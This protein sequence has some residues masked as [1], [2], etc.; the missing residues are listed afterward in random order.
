MVDPRNRRFFRIRAAEAAFAALAICASLTGIGCKRQPPP[1]PPPP[2]VSVGHPIEREVLEWD[3]YTA[4]LE[5]TE[6]VEVRARV[7]GYLLSIHFKDGAMVKKGDLL[8]TI[9]PRPYEASLHRM[10]A[11]AS[12]AKARLDLAQRKSERA[13]NLIG[14]DAI[15][16]EEA[17][18]RSA[19]AR[20]AEASLAAADADIEAAKLELEFTRV[21]APIAGR[22]SRRY[23]TEGNLVNGGIGAQG[24]LLT[25]IVS[26]DP[27]YAYIEADERSFLKYVRLALS[28]ERPSSRD[29]K[30]P[31]RVALADEKS[32]Q[33]E[34]YID[35]VDNQLD[36]GTGTMVGR[37]LL[38]NPDY[39]LTPGLFAR[40]QLPGSGKR[41][42]I[43]L[44]DTAI[45]FDQ[46]V[47]FVWTVDDKQRVRYRPVELGRLYEGLRIIRSGLRPSDR[48]IV[49]GVQRVMPGIIVSPQEAT[50][51]EMGSAALAG[52]NAEAHPPAPADGS[53]GSSSSSTPTPTSPAP[54]PSAAQEGA[55]TRKE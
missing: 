37:A 54:V 38:P 10:Q 36:V 52:G 35:F 43:L 26:L 47:S 41:N 29:Y 42:A 15:S 16:K 17:E 34:G 49:A 32:F 3:E 19:E 7:S 53:E 40:L 4:R 11:E 46:A 27:I 33:H 23:V 21:Q 39:V 18:I 51:E 2:E 13:V 31:V 30:N 8:F 22:I 1:A 45:L 5:A 20:Q 6:V 12:V 48:V 14:R 44:P 25:S 55:E 50:P 28:G 9:D 24:T